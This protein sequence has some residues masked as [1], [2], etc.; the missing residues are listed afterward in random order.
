MRASVL[1]HP[2]GMSVADAQSPDVAPVVASSR[3]PYLDFVRSWAIM[4][5]V[6]VHLLGVAPLA[7]LWWPAPT[8][9]APGMPLVFFVAGALALKSLDPWRKRHVGAKEFWV[10]R[11]RRLLIP[12]WAYLVVA[13]TI[14]LTLDFVRP[15]DQFTV[16]Y[17]RAALS[18]VPLLNPLSSPAGYLG[19]VHL[20]FL[21]AISWLLLLAPG[22]VW[23]HRRFPRMLL[24]GVVA[25]GL[26]VPL[27]GIH[28]SMTFFPEVSS[29]ALFAVFFVLG[30][31]YTDGYLVSGVVPGRRA[32]LLDGWTGA[33]IAVLAFAAAWAVWQVHDPG[34][35]NNSHLVH[36]F[37][38]LG[39]LTLILLARPLI[40]RAANAMPRAL[41]TLN[42]RALT[43]Y[44][45]GW[46]TTALAAEAVRWWGLDGV[47]GTVVFFVVAIASLVAAV[48][49]FGPV[50]DFAA[51]R[52]QSTKS[53]ATSSAPVTA[54]AGALEAG[55]G[56]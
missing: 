8:F 16:D 1:G 41:N 36:G 48:A 23:L 40:L 39:W 26:S 9:I 20:W 30:F 29:I 13:L 15:E 22:L 17:G 11:F 2:Y 21:V 45:W 31:W 43:L 51:R 55:S 12:F 14:T 37:L 6:A 3:D 52:K 44:L 33:A 46:P 54:R 7:L 56:A 38:G 4:R 47:L 50:E 35:I 19:M 10:D 5:V 42:R 34:S 49:V 28:T 18:A 53:A 24:A 32:G 27:L 25:V